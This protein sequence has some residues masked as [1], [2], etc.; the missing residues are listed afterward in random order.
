[1]LQLSFAMFAIE[2]WRLIL[3]KRLQAARNQISKLR[4][5]D[6]SRRMFRDQNKDLRIYWYWRT[7]ERLLQVLPNS[8]KLFLPNFVSLTAKFIEVGRLWQQERVAELKSA[9]EN[10]MS[11]GLQE[12]LLFIIMHICRFKPTHVL[13]ND[14]LILK[15]TSIIS[16]LAMYPEFW[17]CIQLSSFLLDLIPVA[18][19]AGHAP[20]ANTS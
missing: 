7:K 18:S 13:F 5:M 16:S 12:F 3:T 11:V 15:T 14:G 8:L 2:T 20:L 9:Q 10:Q 1:M 19:L 4:F 17:L 6:A